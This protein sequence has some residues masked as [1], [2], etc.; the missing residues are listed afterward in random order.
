M[1]QTS[2]RQPRLQMSDSPRA[3]QEVNGGVQPTP[4]HTSPLFL[5]PFLV[6][7][8]RLRFWDLCR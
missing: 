2:S 3:E 6:N 8:L 4:T 5:A 1:R 7:Y